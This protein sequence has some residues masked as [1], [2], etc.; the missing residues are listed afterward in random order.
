M[1]Q[2]IMVINEAAK[3]CA[4]DLE[5]I[6]CFP[7]EIDETWESGTWVQ[8]SNLPETCYMDEAIL[9][10]KKSENS[11]LAWLPEWGQIVLFP[12][13]ISRQEKTAV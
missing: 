5:F 8:L 9:L 6:D 2:R 1:F 12:N 3:V 10:S 7:C 13:S 11:W 4:D